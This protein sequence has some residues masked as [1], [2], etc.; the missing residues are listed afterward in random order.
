MKRTILALAA[1][2]PFL[3]VDPRCQEPPVQAPAAPQA[4]PVDGIVAKM[5]AGEGKLRSLRL[6][7]VTE[8]KLPGGLAIST[9]GTVH[10]L[11]GEQRALRTSVGFQFGDG[12]RGLVDC[13][14]TAAGIA[15]YEENPAFGEI[16]LRIEPEVVADLEWAGG[17]LGRSDLPGM[18][19][20]RAEAP[21]GSSMLADLGRQ[22]DLQPTGRTERAGEAGTWLAGPRRAKLED[23]DPQLPLADRVE[24]F[25]RDRDSALI[26]VS[27]LQGDQPLQ[28][29]VVEKLEV[30]LELPASTFEVD[31]RGQRQRD[32]QQHL[33]MWDQIEHV[34]RQAEAKSPEGTVRPSRRPK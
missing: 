33:P 14:Q 11:R 9:R 27:H 29:I 5:R 34:L 20:A 31:G 3:A 23:Q 17:V 16:F 1:A 2:L 30:D 21:L 7:L 12:L 32:V 26:E 18:A 19:D 25:V 13:A 10:V 8:G 24:L 22:F 15:L 28:R 6:E 4:G